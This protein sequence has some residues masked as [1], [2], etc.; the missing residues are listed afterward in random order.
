MFTARPFGKSQMK[1]KWPMLTRLTFIVLDANPAE[2]L[3]HDETVF[4]VANDKRGC[5]TIRI[6]HAAS[7]LLQK[8]MVGN[9]RQELLGIELP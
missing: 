5:E 2:L 8:R 3:R 4:L 6:G 7:R 9:E 1:E